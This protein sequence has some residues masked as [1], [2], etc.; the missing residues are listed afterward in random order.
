MLNLKKTKEIVLCRSGRGVKLPPSVTGIEQVR[1]V[2][3]L[4]V[5]LR[6]HLSFS[7]HVNGVVSAV[8]QRFYLMKLLR[9][10]GLNSHGLSIMFNALVWGKIRYAS[11][12]FSGH[13]SVYDL[14]RIQ[15]CLD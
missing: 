15:C 10:Q 13:L 2:K 8:N 12:A 11:Q 9:A 5:I 4:G 14:A 3:L 1:E 6:N 7:A